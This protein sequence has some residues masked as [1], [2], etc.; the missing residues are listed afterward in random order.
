MKT[1]FPSRIEEKV[2][3]GS[4]IV[5]EPPD[6]QKIIELIFRKIEE[7]KRSNK[8]I[9]LPEPEDVRVLKAAEIIVKDKIARIVLIGDEDNILEKAEKSGVDLSGVEFVSTKEK[10]EDYANILY[11][12]RKHKGV[13]KK[14]AKNMLRDPIYYGAVMVKAGDADGMVAG[15]IT[16]SDRVIRAALQ[17]IKTKNDVSV[18]S[19]AF[20]MFIPKNIY[21]EKFSKR[22][23]FVFADC[24][25]NVNPDYKQLAEIASESAETLRMFGIEPRI[26]MLSYMT[27]YSFNPNTCRTKMCKAI[28]YL[29]KKRP[30]LDVEE[31][32]LDAAIDSNVAKIKNP[33]SKIGGNANVLI[34]PD[35]QSGNIG[36]KL[37]ERFGDAEAIGPILQ[38][39]QKPVNDLSR[40]CS[41]EDIVNLVTITAYQSCCLR[42]S[43]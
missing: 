8:R 12:L 16:S 22:G 40:G 29:K 10:R 19:G 27:N 7:V 28:A 39:L 9:V 37:V 6:K 18:V 11:E 43:F 14:D 15:A 38:G 34:F 17:I 24:A 30:D 23:V 5:E 35:L 1:I 4:Y 25:V 31:M 2:K 13:S 41:V 21:G 33:E 26:A 32:Q 36:Y 20:L 3:T 42:K